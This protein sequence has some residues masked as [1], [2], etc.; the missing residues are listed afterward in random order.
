MSSILIVSDYR[1][2]FWSSTTNVKTLTTVSTDKIISN[3]TD[4]GHKVMTCQFSELKYD[5]NYS[6]TYV[7]YTSSEDYGL[8]YKSYVEDAILALKEKG[9]ILLPDYKY[10][11]AHHNKCFMEMLRIAI[12]PKQNETLMTRT[13]GTFEE[14]QKAIRNEGWEE[15]KYV[16]KSAY[17]AGSSGVSSADSLKKLGIEAKRVSKSKQIIGLLKEL[18]RIVLWKGY[19]RQSL[20]AQK[21]IVQNFIEGLQGDYKVLIYGKRY[22]LLYRKNREN[23][24]RAS[25]SGRLHFDLPDNVDVEKLLAYAEEIYKVLDVPMCSLDIASTENTFVLI[26]YQCVCFGP[27]TAER[28]TGYYVKKEDKWE[29]VTESCDLERIMSE[30]IISYIKNYNHL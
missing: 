24:F 7:W 25:G 12:M 28:S 5:T 26:E 20:H 17:G 9:A 13:F 29:M 21:F 11:R 2:A 22:Y 23:D 27:Y 14:L 6:D 10:L 3:L 15:K 1:G 19:I 30:S 8:L 4:Y 16:I 18:R